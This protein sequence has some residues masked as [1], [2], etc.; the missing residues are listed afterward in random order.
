MTLVAA[1]A[2]RAIGRRVKNSERMLAALELAD[3]FLHTCVGKLFAV[4]A[5]IA[6]LDERA[7]LCAQG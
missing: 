3:R 4:G 7:K 5:H 2:G 1:F 6:C